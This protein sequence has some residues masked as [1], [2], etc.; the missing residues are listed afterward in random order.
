MDK[1][2]QYAFNK[3]KIDIESLSKKDRLS[4]GDVM[5]ILLVYGGAKPASV[6]E[7]KGL[8]NYNK[9]TNSTRVDK[10]EIKMM[11]NILTEIGLKYKTEK[12]FS[13]EDLY[14]E[15][16]GQSVKV[17]GCKIEYVS[18][19]I[20]KNQKNLEGLSNALSSKP[21][22]TEKI[23][24]ALGYGKNSSKNMEGDWTDYMVSVVQDKKKGEYV[25]E[26]LATLSFVPD[27]NNYKSK[28]VMNVAKKNAKALKSVAP[29]Y[30]EKHVNSWNTMVN[31]ASTKEEDDG[32]VL[33]IKTP[34]SAG[35]INFFTE[36]KK[37]SKSR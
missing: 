1:T 22:N 37:K 31:T 27:P 2:L 12:G 33:S 8:G 21:H 23:G 36:K 20:S 7:L 28:S 35:F 25:P 10:K 11:E 13:E 9:K 32:L 34:R 3:Y 26:E 5:D 19:L 24:I 29:E 15:K 30:Y 16:R 18:F 14:L 4:E 6:I 17:E